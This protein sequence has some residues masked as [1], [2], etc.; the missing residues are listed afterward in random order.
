MTKNILL[1]HGAWVTPA[2]WRHFAGYFEQRGF[3]C[4]APAWPFMDR[5]PELLRTSPDPALK[6]Q[7]VKGL[8]DHYDRIIRAMPEPPILVGHSFGGLIVQMLAD[9]G[10]G[11]V[12]VAIDPGPPRG[13]LPSIRAIRSALPVLLAWRG[14]QRT[15]TMSFES[16]ASTFA[17]TLPPAA[18][19]QA[20]DEHI[21][22]APGKIYF[23]AAL[24][25]GNGVDFSNPSRPPLLIV[26]GEKDLTSTPDM[27]QAML[28]RHRRSPVRA[29][30][31]QFPGRSHWLIA[32]PGWQTVAGSIVDWVESLPQSS[33]SN[34][35]N[36]KAAGRLQKVA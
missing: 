30:L 6:Q 10:L 27:A 7:T 16:F 15:L 25:I 11:A 21:V 8:V 34:G 29:D 17:N 32:E 13:V 28:K 1:I 20:Y 14:W 24:G 3:S 36:V 18:M 12:A 9:R 19:R 33:G 2:C 35:S 5:P 22:P 31:L 4:H 26:A 23:Q